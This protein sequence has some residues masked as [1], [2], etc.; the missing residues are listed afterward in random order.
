MSLNLLHH[1]LFPATSMGRNYGSFAN[2]YPMDILLRALALHIEKLYYKFQNKGSNKSTTRPANN[3]RVESS[4][5]KKLADEI[6]R[7]NGQSC[8]YTPRRF[9]DTSD[10]SSHT[11]L[12]YYGRPMYNPSHSCPNSHLY[13][14]SKYVSYDTSYHVS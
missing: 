5:N 6:P 3:N 4:V 14:P 12:T 9:L 2:I 7:R 11:L 10:Y 8:Y 13:D 1:S